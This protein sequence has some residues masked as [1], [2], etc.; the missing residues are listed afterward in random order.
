MCAKSVPQMI[1][2]IPHKT[3]VKVCS[4]VLMF[5]FNVAVV[6]TPSLFSLGD[7]E[8]NNGS[9]RQLENSHFNTEPLVN[10]MKIYRLV[11]IPCENFEKERL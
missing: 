7:R 1:W 11:L 9:T 6:S 4:R 2:K 5:Y 10:V 3:T 8:N